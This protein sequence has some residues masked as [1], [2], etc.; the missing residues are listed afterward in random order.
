MLEGARGHHPAAG[1]AFDRPLLEEVGLVDVLDRLLF[2][3]DGRREGREPDRAAANLTAIVSRIVRSWRS[4]PTSS[5]SSSW[6][7]SAA[8]AR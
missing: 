4:R 2:L 6:S 5:T 3:V 7:A 1:G 8:T